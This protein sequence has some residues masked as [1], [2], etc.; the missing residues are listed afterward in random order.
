M[1]FLFFCFT[2]IQRTQLNLNNKT[3][4][5]VNS[6]MFLLP[7]KELIILIVNKHRDT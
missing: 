2:L 3:L 4:S 7:F 1:T 5:K 6:E